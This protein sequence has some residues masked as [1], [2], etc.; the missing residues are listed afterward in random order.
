MH[1]DQTGDQHLRLFFKPRAAV[2]VD[3]TVTVSVVAT[4]NASC[5]DPRTPAPLTLVWNLTLADPAPWTD[6]GRDDQVSSGPFSP[7]RRAADATGLVFHQSSTACR[8]ID[9]ALVSGAPSYVELKRYAGSAAADDTSLDDITMHENNANDHHLRLFFTAGARAAA[10]TVATISLV[11]TPNAACTDPATPAPL[12]VA[13]N[14]TLA[15]TS[16]WVNQ[17]RDSA[18][19]SSAFSALTLTAATGRTATGLA[20]HQSAEG[21][22]QI[23]V[24]LIN[25]PPS[26]VELVRYQGN[27]TTAA[28]ALN[29]IFMHKDQ[30][31]DQH[32]RLFFKPRA[33]VAVDSTVT[34][35]VV[36]TPNASCTDPRTPAPL[37]L[38]WNLTLAD[39]APWTDQ[40]RDDQ[41]SSGPFSPLRR[42]ADATGLVFHQSSTACR[43]IDVALV[44]GAPSYVELKRY[45]GS[46]A[47]DDTSLNDITMHENNANDHHLR[48]FFTAGA[49]AAA[50]T[51]ATISLVATPNAAC[52]DPAT[53]APLT[54]AWNLTLANTSGWVNQGR[55]SATA[56]SAFSAL[57][58]TAATGRTATGLAFHQSAEGCRQIDV[59]LIN[60]PPSY[61]ELVRYQGNVT[62]AATALN[63]IFM[64]KDQ[65]GD[66]HLR[67]FF[68]P[69]A[70]VA[71]D[72]TVTVSVVATPNASCTDPRTP[73]PLT[74]GVEPDAGG[75]G[76]VDR[77]GPRRPGLQR[78]VLAAA[79]RRRRDR[80]RVP[81]KL[82]RLPP[83]RRRARQRRAE[84]R[85]A[86]ALRRQRGR[87]RHVAERHHHA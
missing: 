70:A 51:V 10:G 9:V 16:G 77:P 6:Q 18:T 45:A 5:T 29:N 57:T 36:A 11:A 48:L 55:D 76:A 63:N 59:A 34:V 74:L 79:P 37:T 64:H 41:V 82:D 12:T 69:R 60:T 14:L 8:R 50:G 22:R 44:S 75:P 65:T 30:T 73:A 52:T 2:A 87:G 81:P 53:P 71:V 56:S 24:A 67:L 83:H 54:V 42:A 27:V 31:G 23:D 32:L 58:L 26:Y 28:T 68:K 80:P 78:A 61:V 84:L 1:K 4:P 62:T 72:S 46:A 85:R 47:A 7:L 19:A 3:S 39:P 66:Q 13:W 20:F 25:T 86:Q 38:V 17:G 49:R 35:S 40:G 33:A 43:R 21:C 15:N